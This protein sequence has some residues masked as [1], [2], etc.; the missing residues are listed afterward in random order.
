ME[1][2]TRIRHNINLVHCDIVSW[3]VS[4]CTSINL[5]IL[6]HQWQEIPSRFTNELF[7]NE[8]TQM[9][10]GFV[11]PFVTLFQIKF[12]IFRPIDPIVDII[13]ERHRRYVTVRNKNGNRKNVCLSPLSFAHPAADCLSHLYSYVDRLTVSWPSGCKHQIQWMHTVV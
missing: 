8:V 12:S 11:N 5:S 6:A 1:K 9:K 7:I 10:S 4:Q 13:Y 3:S 2:T